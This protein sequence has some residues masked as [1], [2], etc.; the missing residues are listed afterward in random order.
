[1]IKTFGLTIDIER[2]VAIRNE[3]LADSNYASPE[4]CQDELQKVEA[5]FRREA[6]PY[7]N[8][9]SL[10]VEEISTRLLSMNGL[11]RNMC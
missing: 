8:T 4:Q 6:I 5:M 9:S 2:L 1:M 3:R 11:K 10:S 7:L